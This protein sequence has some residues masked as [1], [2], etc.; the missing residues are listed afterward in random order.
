MAA[1]R[2]IAALGRVLMVSWSGDWRRFHPR[3]YRKRRVL[4]PYVCAFWKERLGRQCLDLHFGPIGIVFAGP[5][6]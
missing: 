2:S 1:I 5:E 6:E 4:L 3:E